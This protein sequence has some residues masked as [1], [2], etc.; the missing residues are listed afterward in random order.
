MNFFLNVVADA[1]LIKA[2]SNPVKKYILYLQRGYLAKKL[3]LDSN[4]E[5]LKN[6]KNRKIER[7]D[8]IILRL[9]NKEKFKKNKEKDKL[10]FKIKK[11]KED[12]GDKNSGY[13]FMRIESHRSKEEF[14]KWR[15]ALGRPPYSEEYKDVLESAKIYQREGGHD[16]EKNNTIIGK[17]KKVLQSLL[18]IFSACILA[19]EIAYTQPGFFLYLHDQT[20]SSIAAFLY[21]AVLV[22]LGHTIRVLTR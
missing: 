4:I 19:F 16:S 18:W 8:K 20:L 9:K 14:E 13:N 10:E 12:I 21:I 2:S 1:I 7:R 11:L 17:L 5:Y 22:T 6:R 3:E 15:S